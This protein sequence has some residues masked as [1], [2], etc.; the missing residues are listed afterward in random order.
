[1]SRRR[2]DSL[3]FLRFMAALIVVFFHFGRSTW[4]A[5]AARPAI[6]SGPQMVTFFFVLSGFVLMVAYYSRPIS[7]GSFYVARAARIAPAYVV[8]LALYCY[9]TDS[10]GLPYVTPIIL[11][12]TFLQSWIPGYPVILNGPDWSLSA[13]AFFYLSFPWLL[14]AI[15]HFRIGPAMLLA[16][17]ALLW[18]VT[19]IA[20][21]YVLN[22]DCY[23]GPLPTCLDLV[24]N[25][26]P[27]HACSFLLGVAG[28]FLFLKCHHGQAS[29]TLRASLF[30]AS[31][32]LVYSLLEFPDSYF[33]L[34]PF[35]LPVESSLYAPAFLTL[36]LCVAYAGDFIKPL[37]LPP[38]I[39][40]GE[41]SY[42]LY[43]FQVPVHKAYEKFGAKY[44]HFSKDIDFYAYLALLVIV[45][46]TSYFAIERPGRKLVL[47]IAQ[48]LTALR[49]RSALRDPK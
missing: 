4:L 23:F 11:H 43:I 9:L 34:F 30:V 40:L 44:V 2:I 22:S 47:T 38:F 8:A 26:P 35:K 48:W 39:L 32:L 10:L 1:M 21:T 36:I 25:F 15:K 20:L 46:F 7:S 42:S 18:S 14:A 31:M 3:T 12:L 16:I 33:G 6:I 41:A 17:S 13:E 24:T 5:T 19:S 45:S 29:R 28:A 37:S 27:S 49:W